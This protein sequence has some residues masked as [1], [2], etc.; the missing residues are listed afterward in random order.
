MKH[1]SLQEMVAR[2]PDP[3]RVRVARQ[4]TN[5]GR[6]SQEEAGRSVDLKASHK[7]LPRAV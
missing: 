4:S 5:S 3:L 6:S 7:L 2:V 1:C